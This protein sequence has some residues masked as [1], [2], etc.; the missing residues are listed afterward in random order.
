[1][2]WLLIPVLVMVVILV[3]ALLY[4]DAGYDGIDRWH[5]DLRALR[6]ASG[7]G[8]DVSPGEEAW[9]DAVGSNVRVVPTVPEP[10]RAGDDGHD[11]HS[12]TLAS[13]DQFRHSSR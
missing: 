4:R 9:A 10:R 1:M 8:S 5:D 6:S 11:E 7:T 3:G 2:T 13:F 12:D